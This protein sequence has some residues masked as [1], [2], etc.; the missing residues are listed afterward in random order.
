MQ[1]MHTHIEF[2][3]FQWWMQKNAC[4]TWLIKCDVWC[5]MV[6]HI[7]TEDSGS[8]LSAFIYFFPSYLN[9][10][11][12]GKKWRME[13]GVLCKLTF[14]FAIQQ[15]LSH[16]HTLTANGVVLPQWDAGCS[17]F[18][19]ILALKLD[20]HWEKQFCLWN[21]DSKYLH[22]T[23]FVWTL[24]LWNVYFGILKLCNSK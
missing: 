5:Q 8:Q 6:R 14:Y 17:Y 10:L 18:D 12:Q 15:V 22:R 20:I 1:I 13:T 23:V 9:F 4:H 16:I 2:F 7:K 3:H 24:R 21:L 11:H 19:W